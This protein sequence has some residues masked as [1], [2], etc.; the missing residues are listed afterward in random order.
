[1]VSTSLF[2]KEAR[3][4][5]TRAFSVPSVY[6]SFGK[7]VSWLGGVFTTSEDRSSFIFSPVNFW[8]NASQL[9][10]SALV[11]ITISGEDLE[12]TFEWVNRSVCV[13]GRP[14]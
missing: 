7:T 12:L 11:A 13:W 10:T 14:A 1:M 6:Q 8:F 5:S 9:E 3:R 4:S 2:H